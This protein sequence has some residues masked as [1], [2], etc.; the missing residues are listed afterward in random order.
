[1]IVDLPEILEA[2][3]DG[4]FDYVIKVVAKI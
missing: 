2:I 4:D 1:V 3:S